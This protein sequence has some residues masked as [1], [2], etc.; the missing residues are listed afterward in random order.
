MVIQGYESRQADARTGWA[1][2]LCYHGARVASLRGVAGDTPGPRGPPPP[3]YERV[4]APKG[5]RHLM[6][7]CILVV[8]R[9]HSEHI[10]REVGEEAPRSSLRRR[11]RFHMQSRE[12]GRE[13]GRHGVSDA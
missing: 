11:L 3:P 9:G 13:R 2:A 4:A 1:P 7:V 6:T 12:K 5:L 8:A 10:V